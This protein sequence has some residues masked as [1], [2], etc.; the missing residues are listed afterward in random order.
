MKLM[1]LFILLANQAFSQTKENSLCIA[2]AD[3]VYETD[4]FLF[5]DTAACYNRAKQKIVTAL[6]K[7][8]KASLNVIDSSDFTSFGLLTNTKTNCHDSTLVLLSHFNIYL[9]SFNHKGDI[10]D[11]ILAG[12]NSPAFYEPETGI[13]RFKRA[14]IYYTSCN[15]L[16][17]IT[18]HYVLNSQGHK[19][20]ERVIRKTLSLDKKGKWTFKRL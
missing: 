19:R 5:S 10:V 17:C 4:F 1:L 18:S 7:Y 2:R 6:K 20:R 15:K 8:K 12:E 3:T 9:L 11:F 14:K 13:G 16:I